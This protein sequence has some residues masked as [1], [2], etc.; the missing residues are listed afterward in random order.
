M[1]SDVDTFVLDCDGVVYSHAHAVPGVPECIEKLK[2]LGKKILFVTNSSA[3]SRLSLALKLRKLGYEH[4]AP[5]DCVTS[6]AVAAA[7]L[8]REHPQ[9]KTAYVVG[10]A[11]LFDELRLRGMLRCTL[12]YVCS[13]CYIKPMNT[14]RLLVR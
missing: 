8:S 4:V 7:Y 11:G 2:R 10:Q 5:E 9:V 3:E 1:I 13:C 6:A 14:S 12:T